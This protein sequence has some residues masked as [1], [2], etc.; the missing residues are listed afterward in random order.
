MTNAF[1]NHRVTWDRDSIKDHAVKPTSHK[2]IDLIHSLYVGK[3]GTSDKCFLDKRALF[4][5]EAKTMYAYM[6]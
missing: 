4:S 3:G 5:H 2:N 6:S 1:F